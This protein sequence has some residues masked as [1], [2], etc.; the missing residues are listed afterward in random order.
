M[1][2]TTS[3]KRRK[4]RNRP[5]GEAPA[6]REPQARAQRLKAYRREGKPEQRV[7]VGANSA[8]CQDWPSSW[9]HFECAAYRTATQQEC[10]TVR[11]AV[12]VI[13]AP[14]HRLLVHGPLLQHRDWPA[15]WWY[16]FGCVANAAGGHLST[17]SARRSPP[18]GR[19]RVLLASNVLRR[20]VA[21]LVA[22]AAVLATLRSLFVTRCRTPRRPRVAIPSTARTTAVGGDVHGAAGSELCNRASGQHCLG[23]LTYYAQ[24]DELA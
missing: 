20:P 12:R 21:A 11:R 5:R 3:A 13:I 16:C 10:V 7:C 18:A 22:A 24:P 23:L 17:A 1:I 8:G 6:P 15:D 9:T 4:Q 14:G 19:W 2:L